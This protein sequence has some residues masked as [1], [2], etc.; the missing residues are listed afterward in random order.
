M[1]EEVASTTGGESPG[2]ARWRRPGLF[3]WVMMVFV[4]AL[5]IAAFATRFGTDP[6]IVASPL[7]NKPIAPLEL[8]YLDRA[9][10]LALRDLEGRIV[11][12]NFWASWCGPCRAEHRYLTDANA[13]Y[14]DRG[15][16][17]V[18]IVHQD[19]PAAAAAFLDELGW[20]E[21]YHYALDPDS[22]AA[23]EFGVFGVPETFFID[24]DGIITAK[25]AGPVT[26][27]SLTG[28]L[29][30]MLGES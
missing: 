7:I 16:T 12:V 11:V 9:G 22:R 1:T 25:I 14:R 19:T 26:P 15:V 5:M 18:G 6:R 17:F 27:E 13:A 23:V 4:V 8:D 28:T 20:G 30:R 24:R 21:G 2:R 3:I 29:D 10:S